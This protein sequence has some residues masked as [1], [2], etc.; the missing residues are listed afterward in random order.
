MVPRPKIPKSAPEIRIS[1]AFLQFFVPYNLTHPNGGVKHD[2][3][4]WVEK[5]VMNTSIYYN[6]GRKQQR[7]LGR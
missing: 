7:F 5:C 2:S 6:W 3:R 1:Y 4:C